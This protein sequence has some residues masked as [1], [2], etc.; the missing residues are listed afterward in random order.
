MTSGWDLAG[1]IIARGLV[2]VNECTAE[3]DNPG[4]PVETYAMFAAPKTPNL[5]ALLFFSI[6]GGRKAV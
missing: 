3:E 5:I 6:V 1:A 4:N 2:I